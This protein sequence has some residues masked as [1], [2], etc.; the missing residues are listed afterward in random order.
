MNVAIIPA[1]GGSKR[2]PRK[3]VRNFCGRPAISWVIEA[4]L[5]AKSIDMVFVSTDDSE[6]EEIALDCGCRSLGSRSTKLA[7]DHTTST[8]V[9]RYEI[10]RL[11]DSDISPD[12]VCQLYPTAVFATP[13]LIDLGFSRLESD[14]GQ[15][16]F[17]FVATE[18][19][20]QV[21]RGFSI[22]SG[23]CIPLEPDAYLLRSQDLPRVYHDAGQFYWGACASWLESEFRFNAR[24]TAVVVPRHQVWDLDTESD[25][26]IAETLFR[27]QTANREIV[28]NMTPEV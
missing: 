26:L 8:E 1:R 25:W 4:A 6:I 24:S 15:T 3:N 19:D 11:I 7:D 10:K 28:H 9:V 14:T 23:R 22:E 27:Q 20:A 13:K 5:K 12:F 18:F 17:S 21:Q 16:L 2:I